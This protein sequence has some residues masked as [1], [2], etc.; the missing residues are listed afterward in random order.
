MRI[1]K[2]ITKIDK[3][4]LKDMARII[5]ILRNLKF[6]NNH[7][8]TSQSQSGIDV[9]LVRRQAFEVRGI[10]DQPSGQTERLYQVVELRAYLKSDDSLVDVGEPFIV[11]TM[12]LSPTWDWVR[13]HIGT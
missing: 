9:S 12:Y 3:D 6:D 10:L 4:G 1:G 7:F 2:P 11:S 13:Y 5:N 8:T